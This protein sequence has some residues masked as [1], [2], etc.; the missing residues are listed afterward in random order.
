MMFS[1]CRAGAVIV[2]ERLVAARW[3]ARVR[4]STR[5]LA[6]TRWH[7]L[8]RT[9]PPELTGRESL[10]FVDFLS[11]FAHDSCM[12]AALV[13]GAS[14]GVGRGVAIGLAAE[15]FTVFAT[16]R[17]IDSS[18]LPPS[19]V[20]IQCD[21]CLDTDTAR[22]FQRIAE[23]DKGL[24]VLVNS[25]WGGYE[26]MVEDGQFTW[27]LP[28]WKQP[29]HRWSSMMDTGVR[30]AFFASARAAEMMVARRRGLIVNVSFW[31]AQK[32]VGNSIYGIAKAA[33]DKMA[34]DM[35]HE[36]RPSGV[37][38][39][40]LYPGLVRTEAVMEAARGGWLDISNSESPEFIGRVIAALSRDPGL[41]GRS[42]QVVVAA[43]LAKEL[44]VRDI[45]DRQP[46]PLTLA[47]V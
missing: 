46:I 29:P 7:P 20:R 2:N 27:G 30:S 12:P 42:G 19:I 31:A 24:D 11:L 45:D 4:R 41:M 15:G 22:V 36:L 37:A 14:R 1:I 3:N 32:Y 38:V 44:N 18:D 9:R 16:G 10:R 39:V 8:A 28:F 25:A 5:R 40:S 23:V 33:T 34:S 21:H 35:A 43:Q 17:S 26:R 47:S 13:T 6:R